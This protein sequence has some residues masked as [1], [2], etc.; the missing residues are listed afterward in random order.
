LFVACIFVVW[1]VFILLY[2]ILHRSFFLLA[3]FPWPLDHVVLP[4]ISLIHVVGWFLHPCVAGSSGPKKVTGLRIRFRGDLHQHCT[5]ISLLVKHEHE[6][7][8]LSRKLTAAG[9]EFVFGSNISLASPPLCGLMW[10]GRGR[11]LSFC[12]QYV[13]K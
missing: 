11:C 7:D 1:W 9:F 6:V 8:L 13:K 3:T 4:F 2:F 12:F 10:L 5:Y